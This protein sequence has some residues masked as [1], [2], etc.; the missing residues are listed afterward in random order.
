MVNVFS[1]HAMALQAASNCFIFTEHQ[2]MLN[3]CHTGS[4]KIKN[5]RSTPTRRAV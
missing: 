5:W 1:I 2:L 3:F 4:Y